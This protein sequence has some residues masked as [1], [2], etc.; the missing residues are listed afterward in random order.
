MF[1]YPKLTSNIWKSENKIWTQ[2]NSCKLNKLVEK[3]FHP[4]TK[5]LNFIKNSLFK[6]HHHQPRCFSSSQQ[7]ISRHIGSRAFLIKIVFGYSLSAETRSPST[8]VSWLNCMFLPVL[9]IIGW[10]RK[11]GMKKQRSLMH[12]WSQLESIVVLLLLGLRKETWL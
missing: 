12:F 6:P 10:Q 2:M 4:T 9:I 1:K 8:A 3:S 11:S 7:V 5:T